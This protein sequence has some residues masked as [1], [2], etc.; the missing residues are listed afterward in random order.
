M[1]GS[2]IRLPWQWC[3]GI[4]SQLGITPKETD[5]DGPSTSDLVYSWCKANWSLNW[6]RSCP[7]WAPVVGIW[8]VYVIYSTTVHRGCLS[9]DKYDWALLGLRHWGV[10]PFC[11][12]IPHSVC[13]LVNWTESSIEVAFAMCW[14]Y[15]EFK[16]MIIKYQFQL[17]LLNTPCLGECYRIRINC[18]RLI[19]PNPKCNKQQFWC[20]YSII[21]LK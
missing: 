17:T 19:L 14:Q 16:C 6:K 9:P 15:S 12:F 10:W 4:T 5:S 11:Y 7:S 13:L 1:L 8:H 3:D 21:C 18:C 2:A 20:I